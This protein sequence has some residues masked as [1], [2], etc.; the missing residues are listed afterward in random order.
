MDTST[1]RHDRGLIRIIAGLLLAVFALIVIHAPLIV[2]VGS[3]WP[4][5]SDEIKAWKELL[6]LTAILLLALEYTRQKQWGELFR[7]RAVQLAAAYALL[8]GITAIFTHAPHMEIIAGLMI[9]LRYVAYSVAVYALLRLYPAYKQ[10]FTR[11][12]VIGAAVVVGFAALQLVLPR[13]FLTHLGYSKSTIAPYITLDQNPDYIR[14]NSTLRGPNPLGQY[15]IIVLAGV[16]ALAV[17]RRRV[18]RASSMKYAHVA[19]AVAAAIA[20]WISYSRSAWLGAAVAVG[21]VLTLTYWQKLTPRSWVIMAT[22]GVILA[23]GTWLIRDTNFYHNVIL[24]DNPTTGAVVTSNQGHAESLA[25]GTE[26]M[27]RQPFGAGI[28]STGSASLTG[29]APLIIENQYLFIAHEVGWL[30]LALFIVLYIVI[31]RELWRARRDWLAL[32]VF[33]SGLGLAL[34]GLLLPV[35][36]DDTVSIV[37]WGLAAVAI[38]DTAKKKGAASRG[39]TTTHKKAKRTA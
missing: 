18:G 8:H 35:W 2:F 22:L 30:G 11:V 13:D 12:A 5:V 14:H 10:S 38:V 33:A 20:L 36:T 26:R 32:S 4:A 21:V 25:D 37:W 9:D 24:H 23:I 1:A 34:V 15:T 16:A 27:L 31:M 6:L 29:D 3:Q 17:A 28:G 39:T 19:F 7:V